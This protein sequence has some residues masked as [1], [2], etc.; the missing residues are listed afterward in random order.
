MTAIFSDDK[1]TMSFTTSSTGIQ[2]APSG[3]TISIANL[4]MIGTLT[5]V[6]GTN[7]FTGNVTATNGMTGKINGEFYG[8]DINEFGG[9]FALFSAGVGTLVGGFG[10]KK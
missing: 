1:Q 7:Y 4:D 5:Y 6:A 3:N 8:P 9:T 10:S 2:G